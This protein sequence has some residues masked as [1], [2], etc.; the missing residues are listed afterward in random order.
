MS[1]HR[2]AGKIAR[3]MSPYPMELSYALEKK[4]GLFRVKVHL[5]VGHVVQSMTY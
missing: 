2:G 5:I 3:K 4:V 1:A